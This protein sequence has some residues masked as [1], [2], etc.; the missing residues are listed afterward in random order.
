MCG[1]AGWVTTAGHEVAPEILRR[2]I[3]CLAHRGPDAEGYAI[4][5]A[6]ASG[7]QVALG[8]CRLAI[9][10]PRGGRQPMR[11]ERGDLVLTYNGEI[12]NFRELRAELARGGHVF[13]DG[14]DTEVLLHAYQ[15]WGDRCVEKLRGM[16]AFALWDAPRNRLLLVRDHFGKKPLFLYQQPGLLVFAS[17]IKALLA[18]PGLTPDLDPGSVWEY[19]L[20]RYVPAPATLFAG[21]RKLLPATVACWTGTS[22][23]ERRYWEPPDHRTRV[24]R[25][26]VAN[27]VATFRA[28]LDDAVRVRMVSDVP[29]GA[30]LSGGIDSSTIVALMTRHSDQPVRTFSVGFREPRYSELGYARLIARAY[31]TQHHELVVSERD[32]IDKLP[33]LVAMRDAPVTEPS[34]I[35]L[36]LLAREASHTVKMVLTGEG[37]DEVLGGYP[38]HVYERYAHVYQALPRLVRHRLVEPLVRA[39]PFP[40][41]RLRIAMTALAL[42]GREDRFPAWFGALAPGDRRWLLA[43]PWPE[44]V[45]PLGASTIG[46]NMESQNSDLRRLLYFDQASW[47]PDNLLER[48]DEMTMAASVEARMPFL[49]TILVEFVSSLPDRYRV[50]HHTTKWILRHA[51]A[52]LLPRTI[53]GRR[54]IGFRLPVREWFQG[55]MRGYVEDALLSERSMTRDY[56]RRQALTRVVDE[57]VTGRR[58]HEKLLWTLLALELWHREYLHQPT[59]SALPLDTTALVISR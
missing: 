44:R 3:A 11:D 36:Y 4:A 54:K 42:E 26:E 48:G 30:F 13:R 27:P 56:Y 8:H 35:P 45:P 22:L 25:G 9:I 32:V 39:L 49:D 23:V 57:H 29:F 20:Y 31:G 6:H 55:P 17:E 52:D 50:R 40:A 14:S 43:E 34:E 37:S 28:H 21:I 51:V 15:E 16:F 58:N 7:A 5:T 59:A 19:L 18:F 53:L 10:A 2:M 33:G 41:S 24:E 12:Y 46:V 47:L 1:I 38:K